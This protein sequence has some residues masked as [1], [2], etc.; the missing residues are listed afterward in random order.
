MVS[1]PIYSVEELKQMISSDNIE[2]R[3]TAARRIWTDW[4]LYDK[5]DEFF[6]LETLILD[7]LKNETA[8]RNTWHYM[9]SLGLMNS[10]DAIEEIVNKLDSSNEENIRGFAADALGRY[11]INQLNNDTLELL[12]NLAEFDPSL[13]VRVNSIR[14]CTNQYKQTKNEIIS[15]R[16]FNL[17]ESQDHSAVQTTILQQIGEIGSLI[18]VPDLIHIMITRRTELD[19]KMAGITLDSIA[20]ANG[21]HNREDLLK[22]VNENIKD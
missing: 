12:W 21:F 3:G 10:E 11:K 18:L 16:L 22:L 13:V 7:L 19:K 5:D 17:L 15:K 1:S 6:Q 2:E 8:G 4:N 9:I 20:K 14:A